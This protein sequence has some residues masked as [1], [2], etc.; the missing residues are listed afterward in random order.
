[1]MA[2]FGAGTVEH[3]AIGCVFVEDLAFEDTAVL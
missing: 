2:A 1:M 3:S